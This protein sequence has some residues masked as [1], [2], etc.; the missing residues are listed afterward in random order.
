MIDYIIPLLACF[1]SSDLWPWVFI[2]IIC[3]CFVACVPT[4]IRYFIGR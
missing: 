3:L 4:L 2:P 1:V